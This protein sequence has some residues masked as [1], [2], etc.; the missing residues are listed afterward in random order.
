MFLNLSAVAGLLALA[1]ID[2]T[3][4]AQSIH[5]AE[6]SHQRIE[7]YIYKHKQMF[8]VIDPTVYG[9]V[10]LFEDPFAPLES[11]SRVYWACQPQHAPNRMA[12]S[13]LKSDVSVHFDNVVAH[14]LIYSADTGLMS[15]H[16][17]VATWQVGGYQ[18]FFI[19]YE[20]NSVQQIKPDEYGRSFA[21]SGFGSSGVHSNSDVAQSGKG[22]WV[23]DVEDPRLV[24]MSHVLGIAL[25]QEN[26]DNYYAH[27]WNFS[28][29][30][31]IG[32]GYVERRT[33]ADEPFDDSAS[34]VATSSTLLNSVLFI[35]F[36]GVAL[37]I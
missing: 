20:N 18:E 16:G 14:G 11:M 6:E 9:A 32:T 4:N 37:V 12:P 8:F 2:P 22:E 24:A 36:A 33:Y 27:A 1:L 31:L 34:A 5:T 28:H 17:Y 35:F 23:T 15:P 21:I 7:E 29:A 25:T 10:A 3:S 26:C 13:N 19:G 30:G